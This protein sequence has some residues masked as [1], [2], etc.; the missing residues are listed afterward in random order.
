MAPIA[1]MAPIDHHISSMRPFIQLITANQ[2]NAATQLNAAIQVNHT[3]SFLRV[4]SWTS[5]WLHHKAMLLCSIFPSKHAPRV[6]QPSYTNALAHTG[7]LTHA[8]ALA[9]TGS[10][11]GVPF[12]FLHYWFNVCDVAARVCRSAGIQIWTDRILP[13]SHSCQHH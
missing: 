12:N 9:H 5:L 7:T 4:S 8:N 10:L 2:R 6:V 3:L 11:M 13:A 1:P